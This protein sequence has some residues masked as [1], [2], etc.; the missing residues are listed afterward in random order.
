MN[1]EAPTKQ[2]RTPCFDEP[3]HGLALRGSGHIAPLGFAFVKLGFRLEV[4]GPAHGAAQFGR[5]RV[6]HKAV[7][8]ALYG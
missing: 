1:K 7:E 3:P 6:F 8:A 4:A 2:R 5:K